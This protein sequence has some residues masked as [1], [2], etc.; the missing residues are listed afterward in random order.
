MQDKFLELRNKYPI[1]YYH[2]YIIEE[3]DSEIVIK[4][5]FEIKGL[6]SFEPK[7][8]LEKQENFSFDKN[9][10]IIN[11]IIFN[12]GMVEVISYLKA[13]CSPKLIVECALLEKEQI[14]FYKKLYFN[15]LGE[16]LYRNNI[17]TS[18]DDLFEIVC[19]SNVSYDSSNI[20]GLTGNLI[21]V[22]GGKDSLVSL[23]LLSKY[24][25]NNKCYIL[26]PR[27]SWVEGVK[28]SDYDISDIFSIKRSIDTRLIEL[29]KEGY[30]NGHTP[31][32][33]LLAMS[34]LLPAYL[35][36]KKN[37]CVSN[38]SSANEATIKNTKINHQYSKSF[39]F[40]TDFR[41]Y[42]NSFISPDFNYYSL[43]RPLSEYQI[44]KYFSKLTNLHHVFH[45]CNLGSKNDVW[46]HECPK[47]LFIYLLFSPFLS[48]DE[49]EDIFGVNMLEDIKNIEEFE[50]LI[51][52][53]DEK[54]F[55][56]VGSRAEVNFAIKKAINNMSDDELPLLLQIYKERYYNIDN[57][58]I[59]FDKY[60]DSN[61]YVSDE[62][63]EI[64]K[65]EVI[66]ND[67][68]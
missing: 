49:L 2:D 19:A 42:C 40:E 45:S 33:A 63:L 11:N 28:C 16:L 43:L 50:K 37:I 38:E 51:G 66:D 21:L 26:N 9:D 22:G 13:T 4:F 67:N 61:N 54:S 35:L 59:D 18:I 55:E 1:F 60:F 44:A 31:L 62:L 41:N 27:N 58:N 30:L 57:S 25:E 34:S 8:V 52:V 17:N 3:N 10:P 56:C 7:W 20:N 15:G 14:D 53:T 12:I 23:N 5:N 48:Q 6:T 64:I 32:S 46:C 24:K 39:E 29:N 47:C 65:N 68:R 36:K